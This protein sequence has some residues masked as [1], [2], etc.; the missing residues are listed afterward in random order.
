MSETVR[1][2]P[3]KCLNWLPQ[4]E[5]IECR[6]RPMYYTQAFLFYNWRTNFALAVASALVGFALLP[7]GSFVQS[8]IMALTAFGFM[9]LAERQRQQPVKVVLR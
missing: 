3:V 9:G 2:L 6:T 7:F 1:D 4:P 5:R 8:L